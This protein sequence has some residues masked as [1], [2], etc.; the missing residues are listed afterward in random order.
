MGAQAINCPS[1]GMPSDTGGACWGCIQRDKHA[2]ELGLTREEMD[3]R[4]AEMEK[5]AA[6][7]NRA[8]GN[9]G[10]TPF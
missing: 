7:K 2:A 8:A 6:A 9:V 10:E 3:R 1:C 5:T 4:I